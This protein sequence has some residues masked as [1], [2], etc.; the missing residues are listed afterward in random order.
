MDGELEEIWKETVMTSQDAWRP[1]RNWASALGE[2]DQC[3]N[4]PYRAVGRCL[5][6]RRCVERAELEA[7]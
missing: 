7:V 5:V 4:C 3:T 2:S 1:G 6:R